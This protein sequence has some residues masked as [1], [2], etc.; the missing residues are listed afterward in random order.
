MR[1]EGRVSAGFAVSPSRAADERA[2][3]T[4]AG[5][6]LAPMMIEMVLSDALRHARESGA[7]SLAKS[8]RLV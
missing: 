5:E 2:H 6:D 7:P 3:G 4:A 1:R 8:P